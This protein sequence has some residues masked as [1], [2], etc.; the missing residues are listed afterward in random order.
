MVSNNKPQ[1]R[2]KGFSDEWRKIRLGETVDYIKG[3][4]FK[5]MSYRSQ[6]IRIIRVS[7]LYRQSIKENGD[8]IFIDIDDSKK[9][10]NYI[11]N[12]NEIIIT[13]VGSKSVM[14]DSAVG[15]PIIVREDSVGLLN[16]N[17]VKLSGKD[18]FDIHFIYSQ[19]LDERYTYYISIVER[20][21]ANQANISLVDLW[22]YKINI[23]TLEEQQKIGTF[24]KTLDETIALH[25]QKLDSTKQFKKAMLQKMFP[26]KGENIPEIRFKWFSEEWEEAKL[27]DYCGIARGTLPAK[28]SEVIGKYPF[29]NTGK[30]ALQSN[31]YSIHTESS[32]IVSGHGSVGNIHFAKG[33]IGVSDGCYILDTN[34]LDIKFLY[35][36]SKKYLSKH[37][38]NKKTG[39]IISHTTKKD[40][41][42]CKFYKPSLEEQEKIGFFFEGLEKTISLQENK[43]D[44]YKQFKKAML[45]K[46]FV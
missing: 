41:E 33:R 45:Q 36:T 17:L 21:N 9:Y 12:K 7:D 30:K 16:Q 40:V 11:V 2:F 10:K 27:G 13:T 31:S 3:F 43:L 26:K 19:L 42:S 35:F 24:F 5:S 37:L 32:I 20:G 34:K 29:Y 1:I 4:A 18:C 38:N 28:T 23:P 6:G 44:S 25:Q 15:R 39:T 22:K 46:M 14:K 8:F